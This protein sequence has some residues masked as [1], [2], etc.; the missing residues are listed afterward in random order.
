M[1]DLY[2]YPSGKMLDIVVR[3]G[4]EFQDGAKTSATSC[5]ASP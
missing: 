3:W 2:K 4:E 1:S 5:R